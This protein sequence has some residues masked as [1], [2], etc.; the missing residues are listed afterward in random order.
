MGKGGMGKGSPRGKLAHTGRAAGAGSIDWYEAWRHDFIISGG[1]ETVLSIVTGIGSGAGA[2][3]E[4]SATSVSEAGCGSA[5]GDEGSSR[6]ATFL[7]NSKLRVSL[8]IIRCCLSSKVGT[9]GTPTSTH[10]SAKAINSQIDFDCLLNSLLEIAAMGAAGS[11]AEIGATATANV[12]QAA[13]L[14]NMI[15]SMANPPRDTSD[16]GASS[17]TTSCGFRLGAKLDERILLKLVHRLVPGH[18]SSNAHGASTSNPSLGKSS[19]DGQSGGNQ[20]EKTILSLLRGLCLHKQHENE[21]LGSSAMAV[22]AVDAVDGNHIGAVS[23]DSA[24]SSLSG[25]NRIARL[26]FNT[27]LTTVSP[28]NVCLKHRPQRHY[29]ELFNFMLGK[30]YA[31]STED[32]VEHSVQHGTEEDCAEGA[33]GAEYIGHAADVRPLQV[34][35]AGMLARLRAMAA[36]ASATSKPDA[37]ATAGDGVAG[38]AGAGIRVHL[39]GY[40]SVITKLLQLQRKMQTATRPE[41]EIFTAADRCA[42]VELAYNECLMSAQAPLCPCPCPYPYLLPDDT[43]DADDEASQE[44]RRVDTEAVAVSNAYSLLLELCHRV[45]VLPHLTER[46]VSSIAG[47]GCAIGFEQQQQLAEQG[48]TDL[49]LGMMSDAGWNFNAEGEQKSSVGHVGLHNQGFT[50]YINSLMQQFF[51]VPEFR[52]GILGA[53]PPPGEVITQITHGPQLYAMMRHLQRLFSFLLLSDSKA[54]NPR[55]FINQ[56]KNEPA[57]FFPLESAVDQQ[58]DALEFLNLFMDRM[59]TALAHTNVPTLLKKCFEGKTVNQIIPVDSDCPHYSEREEPFYH[60]SLEVKNKLNIQQSLDMFVKSDLLEGDN[61]YLCEKCGKKVSA[62]KRTCLASL[63]DTLIIHLKR[64]ELDYDT[65]E[66]QKVNESCAFPL[67][68]QLAPYMKEHLSTTA[69]VGGDGAGGTGG[70]GGGASDGARATVGSRAAASADAG[71]SKQQCTLFRLKGILVHSGTAHSGHYYSII[72]KRHRAQGSECKQG[73]SARTS[74]GAEAGSE[75]GSGSASKAASVA[76]VVGPSGAGSAREEATG[77]EA[78]NEFNDEDVFAFSAEEI[79]TT[80]FGGTR[81]QRVKDY[82]TGTWANKT[83]VQQ[84]NAFMLFY[85]KV[86]KEVVPDAHAA[87]GVAAAGVGVGE[88]EQAAVE[89]QGVTGAAGN[90]S[91]PAK[92]P[93]HVGDESDSSRGS[94]SGVADDGASALVPT[95]LRSAVAAANAALWHRRRIFNE[96]NFNFV[97]DMLTAVFTGGGSRSDGR[98]CGRILARLP[99]EPLIRQM[100]P[101]A[102]VSADSGAGV[103][104]M[105][106][107]ATFFFVE[108]FWRSQLAHSFTHQPDVM[109]QR[110]V[111]HSHQHKLRRRRRRREL[112]DEEGMAMV[113]LLKAIYS[114]SIEGCSWLVW[115]L[116]TG[117][118]D[119]ARQMLLQCP[120]HRFSQAFGDLVVHALLVLETKAPHLLLA[121]TAPT[122]TRVEEIYSHNGADAPHRGGGGSG[123]DSSNAGGESVRPGGQG[124]IDCALDGSGNGAMQDATKDSSDG[125]GGGGSSIGGSS[126]GST[127]MMPLISQ[128]CGI[129]FELL[130]TAVANAST[131]A[132]FF[133]FV[134]KLC[135]VELS[136]DEEEDSGGVAGGVEASVPAG[137]HAISGGSIT[138][139][140]FLQQHLLLHLAKAYIDQDDALSEVLDLS[141]IMEDRHKPSSDEQTKATLL[142]KCV[143]EVLRTVDVSDGVGDGDDDETQPYPDGGGGGQMDSGGSGGS[144]REEMKA[145]GHSSDGDDTDGGHDGGHRSDGDSRA[146]RKRRLS[147][148]PGE[149]LGAEGLGGAPPGRGAA[150]R[151]RRGDHVQPT[152]CCVEFPMRA[153]QEDIKFVMSDAFLLKAFTE[154]ANS[155]HQ[156]VEVRHIVT[157]LCWGNL[158]MSRALSVKIHAFLLREAQAKIEGFFKIVNVMVDVRDGL[159][160]ERVDTLLRCGPDRLQIGIMKVVRRKFSQCETSTTTYRQAELSHD[161]AFKVLRALLFLADG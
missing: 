129:V 30:L 11:S 80:C 16:H 130:H 126:S 79:K 19:M 103:L 56:L 127:S 45:E 44:A 63:P 47:V 152:L 151:G 101:A 161:R 71:G 46:I 3:D 86:E 92:R 37:L 118:K 131:H 147:Y 75:G 1:L 53:R 70:A 5:A 124:V 104:Q 115:M 61:A 7:L 109:D 91:R 125:G 116:A 31:P 14:V 134:A 157:H 54:Y 48:N 68:L 40:L 50:C 6:S 105:L 90:D 144:R 9:V 28:M 52:C 123:G 108:I 137:V 18:V 13:E 35:G 83:F 69:V 57:G 139:N 22:S 81:T 145:G 150:R 29:F 160:R 149:G 93:K 77:A 100:S 51:M 10:K 15:C 148:S 138:R 97:I 159:Q 158:Q 73:S 141:S 38:G 112:D 114:S 58:N 146:I 128:F 78:W 98:D 42:L 43:V 84:K 17:R 27:C 111:S 49:A 33:E 94:D 142:L 110:K 119:W 89:M 95:H 36:Y 26:L 132:P 76:R 120:H 67:L 41:F 24:G 102:D 23:N 62:A 39:S 156:I 154:G 4:G 88:A 65:L 96:P 25:A 85:D 122:K 60:I 113:P 32:N 64:F 106:Q 121:T 34:L 55:A 8:R 153:P 143:A 82:K 21:A 155:E 72:Q 107:M 20:Q 59:E 99:L 133:D 135:A 140:A 136:L 117:H 74:G 66:K 87:A 12:Q 2:A